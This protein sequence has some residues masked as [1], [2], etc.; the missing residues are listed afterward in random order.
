MELLIHQL[1]EIVKLMRENGTVTV[2]QMDALNIPNF[3][4]FDSD[5]KA[6]D[7]RALHNKYS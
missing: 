5:S 2:A 3:N 1:P 4:E 6:K 7:E